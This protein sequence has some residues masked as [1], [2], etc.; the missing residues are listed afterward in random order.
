MIELKEKT[1]IIDGEEI[2]YYPEDTVPPLIE[3]PLDSMKYE[4]TGISFSE[5]I[6]N[7]GG[8]FLIFNANILNSEDSN[9]D[10]SLD[11]VLAGNG[12]H[13]RVSNA[14]ILNAKW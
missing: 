2:E 10:C 11:E 5:A 13:F 6:Q 3:S 14:D 4:N 9:S 12:G 7:N 8:K 1:F